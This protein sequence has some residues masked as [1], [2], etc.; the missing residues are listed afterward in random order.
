MSDLYASHATGNVNHGINI[1]EPGTRECRLTREMLLCGLLHRCPQSA[2]LPDANSF[3]MFQAPFRMPYAPAT[4]PRSVLTQCEWCG[5]RDAGHVQG[6]DFGPSSD[7]EGGC[8]AGGGGC[9]HCPARTLPAPLP[10]SI[11]I[12]SPPPQ[13][14]SHSRHY[15]YALCPP[16]RPPSPTPAHISPRSGPGEGGE[17]RMCVCVCGSAVLAAQCL[18]LTEGVWC[19]QVDTIIMARQA[20][21]PDT[22]RGPGM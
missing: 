7:Q 15:P 13:P 14:P 12:L 2:S 5:T 16:L 19:R 4:A 1:E 18:G 20:G 9:D 17:N 11:P 22:S 8:E 21:G 3:S 6:W 10:A